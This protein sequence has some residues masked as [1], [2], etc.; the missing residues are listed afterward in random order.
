MTLTTEKQRQL[1]NEIQD[2][3]H[4]AHS[5]G[6]HVT[7]RALNNAK[8]AAG[9]EIAGDVLAAGKAARGVRPRECA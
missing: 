4:R 5:I 2:L 1:I 9:W 7:A 8:N 3:E 6:L